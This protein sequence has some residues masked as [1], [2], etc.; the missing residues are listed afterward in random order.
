MVERLVSAL[1]KMLE[2]KDD[3]NAVVSALES[4][5]PT[6]HERKDSDSGLLHFRGGWS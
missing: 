4:V 5:A 6:S 2:K 1:K 3:L